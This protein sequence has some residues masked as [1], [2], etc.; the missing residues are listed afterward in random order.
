MNSRRRGWVIIVLVICAGCGKEPAQTVGTGAR[1]KTRE[2][3]E[4]LIARDWPAA[5]ATLDAD[6]QKDLTLED[7][8]RLGEQYLAKL[9]FAAAKVHV[10]FCDERDT[11][12]IA[13]VLLTTAT[14]SRKDSYRASVPLKR[15]PGGWR[16]VLSR[17]FFQ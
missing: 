6:S 14:D 7:V 16:I 13:H 4:A 2:F 10:R 9:G 1:E 8:S 17:Q 3:F 12:A 15:D 5:L 11:S